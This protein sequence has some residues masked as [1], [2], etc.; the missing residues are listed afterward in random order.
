MLTLRWILMPLVWWSII[1]PR[2]KGKDEKKAY[3]SDDGAYNLSEEAIR[4]A[5][6]IALQLPWKEYQVMLS[7]A[8]RELGMSRPYEKVLVKLI[9]AIVSSF[10]FE[11]DAS[12]EAQVVRY[13]CLR[14]HTIV[15]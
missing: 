6:A 15:A 14:P 10:H 3:Q 13:E 1:D 5:A 11:L 8:Q 4:T 2:D 7:D 9:C 12:A